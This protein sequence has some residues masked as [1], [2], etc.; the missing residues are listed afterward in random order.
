MIDYLFYSAKLQSDPE[1]ITP[2]DARTVLPSAE[3]PSDHV[4]IVARFDWKV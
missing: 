3:Q 4:A 1:K 2:I